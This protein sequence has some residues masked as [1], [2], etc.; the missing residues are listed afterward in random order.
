MSLVTLLPAVSSSAALLL[1]VKLG[2]S[3]RDSMASVEFVRIAGDRSVCA[4]TT[5]AADESK[6][7]VARRVVILGKFFKVERTSAIV[8]KI[9]LTDCW[10]CLLLEGSGECS[11]I[12]TI[13]VSVAHV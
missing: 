5:V 3:G 11:G 6:A 13:E 7:I 8:K 1:V 4:D 2:A 9:S 12:E 10:L